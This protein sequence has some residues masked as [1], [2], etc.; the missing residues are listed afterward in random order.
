MVKKIKITYSL[1]QD[2]G[3][4]SDV[5]TKNAEMLSMM[6]PQ[7]GSVLTM[8]GKKFKIQ[9]VNYN[10]DNMEIDVKSDI[11]CELIER[12]KRDK[13][14]EERKAS[15]TYPRKPM[16]QNTPSVKQRLGNLGLTI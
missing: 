4:V 9:E 6:V 14:I 5:S 3:V 15:Y 11:Y 2:I 13:R 1:S 12:V 16:G 8:R 7:I 10:L